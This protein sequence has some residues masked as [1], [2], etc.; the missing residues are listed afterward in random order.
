MN[1]TA[2]SSSAQAP[3]SPPP[4]PSSDG[5]Y[6]FEFKGYSVFLEA[7]TPAIDAARQQLKAHLGDVAPTFP[8][9]VTLVY[10]VE[11]VTPEEM[12][13]RIRQMLRSEPVAG[14]AV[15]LDPAP[16][17]YM[18]GF[19]FGDFEPFRMRYLQLEYSSL[20]DAACSGLQAGLA[21]LFPGT[22]SSSASGSWLPHVSLLYLNSGDERFRE[23]D[24]RAL[25]A[26]VPGLLADSLRC[27]SV[28]LYSTK[29][30]PEDWRKL[31]DIPLDGSA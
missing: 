16:T 21:R 7:S 27:H 2:T 14:G 30:R 9:H 10:G 25:V 3:A 28:A 26:E 24:A 29:G 6:S 8:P 1:S 15:T 5:P 19:K 13:S 12:E 23:E 11:S 4:P 18:G 17:R 31:A 22:T 20:A